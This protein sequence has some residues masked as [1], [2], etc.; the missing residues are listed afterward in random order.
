VD[1]STSRRCGGRAWPSSG[2]APE[3]VMGLTRCREYGSALPRRY[4]RSERGLGLGA[5]PGSG[6]RHGAPRPVDVSS[7]PGGGSTF[8]IALPPAAAPTEP[9][10]G[11]CR[12]KAPA[13]LAP[14]LIVC[15]LLLPRHLPRPDRQSIL[16]AWSIRC[17]T[18]AP[19]TG[20]ST[21]TT[22]CGSA[23]GWPSSISTP[24]GSRS[25]TRT[26]SV[27]VVLN[28]EIYNFAELR[29]RLERRA[30]LPTR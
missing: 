13:S 11:V 20:V 24:G 21:S 1:A 9:F 22:R 28:G 2:Q 3:T 25:P 30:P 18:A 19:T 6:D 17:V 27:H 26:P 12:R 4:S 5:E 23:P 16:T 15:G 29:T 8:T 7:A 14:T 10:I